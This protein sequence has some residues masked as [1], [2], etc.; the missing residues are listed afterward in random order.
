MTGR[1]VLPIDS[2]LIIGFGGPTEP[3]HIMPF[4]RKVVEGRPVPEARLTEVAHH[5]EEVGGRSPYNELTEHQ[6][7]A[8]AEWLTGRGRSLPVHVGMRNWH[9]FLPDTVRRMLDE[10]RRHAAGIIL[11][12][13]RCDTSWER[14]M[15]D[16]Q[17]ALEGAGEGAPAVTYV[18]P[19]HDETGFLEACAARIE[20]AGGYARG[21]WPA[22]VPVI[23]TAHSIP[24]SMASGSPYVSDLEASCRGVARILGLSDWQIA[25]QS[26]SGDPRT[27]WLEPDIR[28]VLRE[29]GARGIGEVVLQAIG[30]LCDHV[31]V[32]Y[33]L[34]IEA[35]SVCRELGIRYHRAPCVNAHPEFIA[36]LGRRILALEAGP[37]R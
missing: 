35:A 10:G 26:R 4:L 28:E 12:A 23:F 19:W 3:E 29:R 32:L 25:Y 2:V 31:E 14:Y 8:L 15:R 9:P 37:V 22:G 27:P 6:A 34:D 30:F 24:A 33:D 20:Q 7:R 13:H 11:S 18:P 16:V 17:D 36:M 21:R 5:Y 1:A